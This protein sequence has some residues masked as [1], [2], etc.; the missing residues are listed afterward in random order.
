[1]LKVE[2]TDRIS[3]PE[4]LS[5]PWVVEGEDIDEEGSDFH[6]SMHLSRKEC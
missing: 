1:M 3:L 4:V 2:P 6:N 5:H